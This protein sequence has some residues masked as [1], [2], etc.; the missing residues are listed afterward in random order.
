[1]VNREMTTLYSGCRQYCST[2]RNAQLFSLVLVFRSF[3]KHVVMCQ[4]LWADPALNISGVTFTNFKIIL[5]CDF[6]LALLHFGLS[7]N[8]V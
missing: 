3:A 1:M 5:T 6:L 2:C 4:F 7:R 8:V